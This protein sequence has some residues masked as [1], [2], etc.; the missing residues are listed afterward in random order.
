MKQILQEKHYGKIYIMLGMNEL[1]YGNTPMYLKQYLQ[2]IQQIKEWLTGCYYLCD[3][4]S[5][6]EPGEE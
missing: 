1:G 2:V 5:P 4:E 3:G 6:C